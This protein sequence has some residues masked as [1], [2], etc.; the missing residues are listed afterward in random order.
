MSRSPSPQEHHVK[1]E[2]L[3][4]QTEKENMNEVSSK[5]VQTL[6]A[7]GQQGIQCINKGS[8]GSKDSQ[9]SQGI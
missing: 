7:A 4:I 3:L 2:I 5:N 1:I 8:K 6:K 9:D